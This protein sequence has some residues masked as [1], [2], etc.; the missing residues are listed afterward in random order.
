VIIWNILSYKASSTTI[1]KIK[2]KYIFALIV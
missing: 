2:R 1:A